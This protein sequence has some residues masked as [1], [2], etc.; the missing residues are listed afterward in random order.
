MNYSS[1]PVIGRMPL[2]V[3]ERITI[4]VSSALGVFLGLRYN[5]Y[6]RSIMESVIPDSVG[7]GLFYEGTVLVLLTILIVYAT[8]FIEKVMN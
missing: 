5:D 1:T 8:V 4:M 2:K 3:R 7:H 6:L